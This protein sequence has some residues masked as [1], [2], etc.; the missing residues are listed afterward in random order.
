MER[1]YIL[2]AKKKGNCSGHGCLSQKGSRATISL[3]INHSGAEPLRGLLLSKPP[4]N[5]F[6]DLGKIALS[7]SGRGHLAQDTFILPNNTTLEAFRCLLICSDWPEAVIF[8]AGALSGQP[9]PPLWQLQKLVT[10]H[11]AVP[12]M[13]EKN[14]PEKE[15][16]PQSE[17]PLVPPTDTKPAPISVTPIPDSRAIMLSALPPLYWPDSLKALKIYFDSLPPFAPFDAPGWRFVKVKLQDNIPAPYCAVGI[18]AKDYSVQK[19]A[20]ALPAIHGSLPPVELRG[21]HF[22]TGRHGQGYWTLTQSIG[23]LNS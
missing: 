20:Y 2:L 15:A 8:A 22:E 5:A 18:Y 1:M 17:A 12:P 11:F 9:L 14:S 21:Y 7:P 10:A 4:A 23:T 19:V 16:T 13:Q 3:T 6:I